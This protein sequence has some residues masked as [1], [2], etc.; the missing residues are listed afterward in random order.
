[1]KMEL[2][3]MKHNREKEMWF[4]FLVSREKKKGFQ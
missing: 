4:K 1:M 2:G 3:L